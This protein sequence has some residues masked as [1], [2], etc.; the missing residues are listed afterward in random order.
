MD[1]SSET[2]L[3]WSRK[4][5]T[6]DPWLCAPAFRRVCLDRKNN[7]RFKKERAWAF[8]VQAREDILH[9]LIFGNLAVVTTSFVV[10][11]PWLC[12]PVFQRVCSFDYC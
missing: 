8:G 10:V 4:R 12:V 2:W 3:S 7:G 6:V 1:L 9:D 11:D 5:V